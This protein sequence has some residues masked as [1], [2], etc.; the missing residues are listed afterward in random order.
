MAKLVKQI[1]DLID[2]CTDKGLTVY[3][4]AAQKD[5]AIDQGQ[6]ELFRELLKEF[7]KTSRT[8]NWLLPFEKVASITI[9]AKVGPMP[10]DFEQEIE[11]YVTVSG[12]KYPVLI[13]ESGFFRRRVLDPV[14]PPSTTNLFA[15]IFND[16]TPKI[17]VSND[18]TPVVVSYWARPVKPA[19]VTTVVDGYLVYSDG[20]STDVLWSEMLLDILV[21]KTFRILGI[22]LREFM[23]AQAGAPEEPKI[24][25]L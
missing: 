10:T 2:L 12:V 11:Y 25:T 23:V 19:Y 14:D 6:M 24:A 5:N 9:T 20:G 13:K 15:M 17:E 21:Q 7:P 1:H 8:R 18:I 4:S 3:H 16:T 22:N